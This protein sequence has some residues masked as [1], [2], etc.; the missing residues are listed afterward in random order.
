MTQGEFTLPPDKVRLTLV[1][2]STKEVI[3]DAKQSVNR[4][5]EYVIQTLKKNRIKVYLICLMNLF[6][7]IC[8][9]LNAFKV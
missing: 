8:F 2:K 4:R 3:E 7:L 5:S 6:N 9:R 1:I